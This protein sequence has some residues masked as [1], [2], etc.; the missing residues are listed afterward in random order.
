MDP[1]C[2]VSEVYL[3]LPIEGFGYIIYSNSVDAQCDVE[4]IGTENEKK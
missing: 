2:Q 1:P 4:K 3:V